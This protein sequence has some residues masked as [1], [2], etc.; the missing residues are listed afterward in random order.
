MRIGIDARMYG[1]EV[2]G[3]GLGRYVEQLV[4]HLP[5]IDHQNRYVFIMKEG[6]SGK[7]RVEREKLESV[8]TPIHWYTLKEQLFLAPLIDK[9]KLDLV[10]F[11]HWNV[12]I[13]LRTPFVVTIHDLILLEEPRSARATTKHPWIYG[14][15]YL[16]FRKVLTHAIQSSKKIIAV[17]QATKNDILK[18]FP[19]VPEDKISVIYEGVTQLKQT[20]QATAEAVGYPFLLYIGN[21]YPHKNL[22]TLLSAFSILHKQIPDLHLVI[23]GRSD[24]FFKRLKDGSNSLEAVSFIHFEE[25]PSDER[26]S[27][28]YDQAELYVFPSHIE[29]FG[30][31]PLEAMSQSTPVACSDIPSL[32]EILGNAAVYFPK[33]NP[34]EIAKAISEI[35]NDPNKKTEL[36]NRG[37]EQIKN[38]SW[39]KMAEEIVKLYNDCAN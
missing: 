4:N 25:N 14:L 5:E 39:K 29:G 6:A 22:E 15:K 23:A 36:I 20:H 33:N 31:P 12:P 30:L 26:L 13:K 1:P 37:L 24:V 35:I 16:G 10:H 18:H 7:G 27:E 34:D 21:C 11:P 38:Y 19:S 8:T 17:S 32:K 28:L 3:G 2:G 9:Q